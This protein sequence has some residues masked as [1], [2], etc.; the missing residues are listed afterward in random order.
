VAVLGGASWLSFTTSRAT[1]DTVVTALSATPSGPADASGNRTVR[2]AA[3]G[4]LAADGP[5]RITV[6]IP[7]GAT[8]VQR[9]VPVTEAGTWRA[10]LRL[11]AAQRLTVSLYRAGDTTAYRTLAISA[12]D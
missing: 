12:V 10:F 5:Y 7:S 11:P 4:L 9:T 8:T 1:H 3:S 2:V 6:T